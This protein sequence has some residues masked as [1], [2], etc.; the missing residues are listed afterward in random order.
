VPDERDV[1]AVAGLDVRHLGVD[2]VGEG[3]PAGVVVDAQARAGHG[4]HPVPGRTQP[5]GDRLPRPAAVPGAVLQDEV[6]H[7]VLSS[8]GCC[9]ARFR[10]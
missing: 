6:R 4:T 1:A 7:V 3:D 9:P 5:L 10:G 8:S 2:A